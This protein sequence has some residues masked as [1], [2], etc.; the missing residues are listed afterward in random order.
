MLK[1][2]IYQGLVERVVDADTFDILVDLG[3]GISLN[4]RFRLTGATRD[5]DAPETWRPKYESERRHGESATAHVKE[6]IEGKVVLID[7]VK[8]GKYRYVAVVRFENNDG[9]VTDLAEHLFESGYQKLDKEEYI[10]LDEEYHN[11]QS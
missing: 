8:R 4:T 10:R 2:W 3:F 7:S 5:F 11:E 6:L 9:V 1:E